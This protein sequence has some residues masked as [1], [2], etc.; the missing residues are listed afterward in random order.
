MSR[1]VAALSSHD[2][3][4]CRAS[5]DVC[6]CHA[7]DVRRRLRLGTGNAALAARLVPRLPGE[8]PAVQRAQLLISALIRIISDNS[9]PPE[10]VCVFSLRGVALTMWCAGGQAGGGSGVSTSYMQ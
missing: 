5:H 7:D 6:M 3:C 10:E 9:G 2:A 4:M 8:V 1:T